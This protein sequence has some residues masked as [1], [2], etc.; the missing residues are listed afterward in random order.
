MTP[1]TV[2]RQTV[3]PNTPGKRWGVGK[4]YQTPGSTCVIVTFPPAL[5]EGVKKES[6]LL[7]FCKSC[8]PCWN[9]CH[10]C[11]KNTCGML[12]KDPSF[13]GLTNSQEVTPFSTPNCNSQVTWG[14]R[15]RKPCPQRRCRS[16]GCGRTAAPTQ[17]VPHTL[18][19]VVY[20]WCEPS[21]AS[22]ASL[23][24]THVPPLRRSEESLCR[25]AAN[26]LN[27]VQVIATAHFFKSEV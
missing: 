1:Y 22:P 13:M 17:T 6:K 4:L 21:S 9:D 23:L 7:P 8:C 26:G 24:F 18:R 12:S 3:S 2:Y 15:G 20:G 10:G 27:V 5:E 16:R 14:S 25:T 11:G 19:Q